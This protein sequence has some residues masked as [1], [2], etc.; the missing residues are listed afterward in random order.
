MTDLITRPSAYAEFKRY[1]LKGVGIN[2]GEHLKLG[3]AETMLS[4]DGRLG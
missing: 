3:S 2:M 1:A 4:W